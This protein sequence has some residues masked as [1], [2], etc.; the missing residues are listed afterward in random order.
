MDPVR[1]RRPLVW[2]NWQRTC[3][4]NRWL[5]V[6][7]PSPAH[8]LSRRVSAGP[9][10]S[11]VS[12]QLV[13]RLLGVAALP[14]SIHLRCAQC[15]IEVRGH[16]ACRIPAARSHELRLPKIRSSVRY[17]TTL[18]RHGPRMPIEIGGGATSSTEALQELLPR[19]ISSRLSSPQHPVMVPVVWRLSQRE[20]STGRAWVL[21]SRCGTDASAGCRRAACRCMPDW[22]LVRFEPGFGG[23]TRVA[24]APLVRDEEDRSSAGVW[25]A[26]LE[27]LESNAKTARLVLILLALAV[28]AAI[29]LRAG[30]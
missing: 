13:R 22:W 4:V 25:R 19:E 7:V 8:F 18:R 21:V 1:A 26:V 14:Q 9:P 29:A 16:R 11:A 17:A 15:R 28:A 3:L 6:R 27:A 30:F 20:L 12:P 23:R 10:R 5:G 24:R 2:R